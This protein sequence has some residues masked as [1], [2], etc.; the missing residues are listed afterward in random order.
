MA[1]HPQNI[2][3]VSGRPPLCFVISPIGVAEGPTRERADTVLE[4]IIKPVAEECGYRVLRADGISEPG[5]ISSQVIDYII[6]ADLVVADL[7]EHNANVFY[8]LALRH[9]V[10]KPIIHIIESGWNLPFDI[11]GQRTIYLSHT[12]LK[13]AFSCRDEMKKQIDALKKYPD[14]FDNPISQAIDM[15]SLRKTGNAEEQV[16]VR[17]VEEVGA[18]SRRLTEIADSL[19]I[20]KAPKSNEAA[21]VPEQ[22]R[23]SARSSQ[24]SSSENGSEAMR[25]PDYDASAATW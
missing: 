18:L 13:S 6:N 12:S 24:R 1:K 19:G 15:S 3:D 4:Y 14:S 8:E 23:T 16:V 25:R 9:V 7:T 2:N 11:A 20:S 21:R 22:G 10:R 17:L 5:I